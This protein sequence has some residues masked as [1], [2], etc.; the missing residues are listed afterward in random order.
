ME[1]WLPASDANVEV[2]VLIVPGTESSGT[3]A[4][5]GEGSLGCILERGIRTLAAAVRMDDRRMILGFGSV[6]VE[7]EEEKQKTL[8]RD[9]PILTIATGLGGSGGLF[10]STLD[11]GQ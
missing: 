6:W 5:T 4:E 3:V 11:L 9:R 8:R 7:V 2:Q 10:S 1:A